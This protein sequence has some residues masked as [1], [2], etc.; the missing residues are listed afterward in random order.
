MSSWPYRERILS[1][2]FPPTPK[3]YYAHNGNGALTFG[4]I[5][6]PGGKSATAWQ[7]LPLSAHPKRARPNI[8]LTPSGSIANVNSWVETE[9]SPTGSNGWRWRANSSAT[10]TSD[11][12]EDGVD[13]DWSIAMN[14]QIFSMW[15]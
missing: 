3:V 8:I 7:Y 5:V 10:S 12:N 2:T 6:I 1:G 15:A 14:F 11:V 9:Y 4:L 13:E